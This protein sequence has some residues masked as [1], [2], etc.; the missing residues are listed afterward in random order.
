MPWC[1]NCKNEYRAGITFCSD[2]NALLVE[3][4][5]TK[6]EKLKEATVLL[7]KTEGNHAG[8]ITK[9]VDFL[10]YSG[11]T[12]KVVTEPDGMVAAYTTEKEFRDAKRLFRAYYSVEM[13]RMEAMDAEEQETDEDW[14]DGYFGEDDDEDEEAAPVKKTLPNEEKEPVEP[15][16]EDSR[17]YGG[18]VARYENYKSSGSVFCILGGIGLFI[19]ILNYM[20]VLPIM[21]NTFSSL[22]FIGIF[23]LFVILGIVSYQKAGTL[24]EAADKEL[25]VTNAI[26]EWL[27]KNVTEETLAECDKKQKASSDSVD[28]EDAAAVSELEEFLYLN[29]IEMLTEKL[30]K[31]FPD[32]DQVL[33]EELLEEFYAKKFD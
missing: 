9:L 21:S 2:C 32:A 3:D 15:Q 22:V 28:M 30:M 29:R 8:F 23:G 18:A 17:K 25:E 7:C 27:E 26:K 14:A 1:P 4:L 24:K 5:N 10:E 13:E 16:A 19:G 31:V 11:V 33:A 6:E 12:A 20:D